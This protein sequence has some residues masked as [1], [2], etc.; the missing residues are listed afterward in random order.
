MTKPKVHRNSLRSN[1][2]SRPTHVRAV[3]CVVTCRHL[4]YNSPLYLRSE[5]LC[6][7]VFLY[8]A[9]GSAALL[10]YVSTSGTSL[11]VAK[12]CRLEALLDRRSIEQYMES[13]KR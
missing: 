11:E 6:K 10:S 9:N 5:A 1:A 7:A 8:K 4:D 2:V 12:N 3:D 13:E